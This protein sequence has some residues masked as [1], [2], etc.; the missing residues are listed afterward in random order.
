MF[1]PIEDLFR[2][3]LPRLQEEIQEECAGDN[4]QLKVAFQDIR[5]GHSYALNGST[6]GWAASMIK[7]P[8]LIAAF[9]SIDEGS[10]SL[11]EELVID[12]KFTLDP[13]S[14]ISYRLQHSSAAVSELLNYMVLASC[15]ESTNMLADRIGIPYINR[16]MEQAGCPNTR[17]SHLLHVG[18]PLIDKGIDGTSSNTTAAEEMNKLMAGIYQKRIASPASCERMVNILEN[19]PELEYG[20][21]T[22]N[23]LIS[24]PLPHGT[25][26]GAK[27]GILEN[28]VMETAVVNGD[29]ALTIMLNKLSPAVISAASQIIAM[30]SKAVFQ[31]YYSHE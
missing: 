21:V 28:D 18:A 1:T 25:K 22:V 4:F 27:T 15:N 9:R 17:M 8:V 7:I 10:L 5:S 14:E 26:I 11:E 30:I 6:L 16:V 20:G 29:Y 12:H 24:Q 13:T 19:A 31:R 3:R 2:E 23:H